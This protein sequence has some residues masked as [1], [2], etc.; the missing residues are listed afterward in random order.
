MENRIVKMENSCE[1]ALFA[2]SLSEQKDISW[3]LYFKLYFKITHNF[4][5]N[6]V[7]TNLSYFQIGFIYS[8]L[9]S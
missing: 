5:P 4:I 9:F 8:F 1:L 2:V 3:Q 6:V 7:F